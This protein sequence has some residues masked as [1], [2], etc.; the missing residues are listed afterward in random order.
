MAESG[1][2]C[3]YLVH[4]VSRFHAEA[5][6]DSADEV[7]ASFPSCV[8]NLRELRA[9]EVEVYAS[10]ELPFTWNGSVFAARSAKA[11]PRRS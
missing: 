7:G 1:K 8:P 11:T 4:G 10:F 3:E 9:V 2:L 5:Q 6:N